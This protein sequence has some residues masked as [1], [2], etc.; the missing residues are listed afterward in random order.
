MFQSNKMEK[1]KG[2]MK[3]LWVAVG[4]ALTMG[5]VEA[6]EPGDKPNIIFILLD[7]LGKEWLSCYGGENINTP[8]IDKLAESGIQFHNAYSMPQCTP[9]RACFMT[10]QYPY[11][12]GWVNHWDAPRWGH[13]Y[14]DW[15]E[16]PSIARSMKDAGYA[17]AAAGKWQLNDFRVHPDAMVRHGFDEFCMWTGAEG[18]K[19]KE[20]SRKSTQRYWDPY[21]HTK[22]GSK[23]YEGE[24][25]PDIYNQFVIDFIGENKD[26]PFFV[27]YPMALPH[28]P[29]VHTPLKPEAK[30]NLE[31][32]VAMVEY[33]DHLLGKIVEKLESEKV[34]NN[35]IIVWTC[36]NG[37]SGQ[38]SNKLNGRLV[39]GGKATTTENGVN[40]PF[41]VSCPGLVP[42]GEQ[43][44][45]L[46]DFS[47]MYPTFIEFAGGQMEEGYTYDGMSQHEV[48]LG[49][50]EKNNRDWVLGM[51]SHP[52]KLTHKGVESAYYFRDRVIRNER[53]KL[54]VG[55]D[56]KP[57][58][59][60]DLS[61]DF[62]EKHNLLE[63]PDH[64]EICQKLTEVIA[65]FPEKDNDPDYERLAPV[66]WE[67][68]SKLP[69]QI[70]KIGHPDN[71][72]G[73]KSVN[74]KKTQKKEKPK[75]K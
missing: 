9:S 22:T 70:H 55:A 28:G 57:S 48:F 12:N 17:T 29:M 60:V 32:H 24:F 26:Q 8:N 23:T 42:S 74:K 33:T 39:R 71:P 31:K 49:K 40:T 13:A 56:R 20:H 44:Q 34:R 15:D 66:G 61:V 45:A 1:G 14:F 50:A 4:L 47:D 27:Y 73:M 52:A 58:K 3:T 63:S 7:D 67:K 59:V 18:A 64:K 38:F 65:K 5:L 54:F 10:G 2:R 36:D 16:S 41:I 53:Y 72:E 46:L 51:G 69:S 25:G 43:S 21:I 11:R 37:T 35:T 68:K 62:A 19:D 30:S 6:R 75:K